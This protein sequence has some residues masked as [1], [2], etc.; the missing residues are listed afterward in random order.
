[1]PY[2]KRCGVRD[3]YII[4]AIRIGTKKEIHK[5][6]KDNSLRIIFELQFAR[7]VFDDFIPL[8]LNIWRTF[9][10]MKLSNLKNLKDNNNNLIDE[11]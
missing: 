10:L 11:D 6:S 2:I 9:S 8:H 1:M 7:Q 4:K 5:E 3:L